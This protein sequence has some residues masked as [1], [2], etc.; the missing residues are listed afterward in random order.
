MRIDGA[1]QMKESLIAVL[2]AALLIPT[3]LLAHG[4]HK[5]KT[6]MGT[7]KSINASHIDLKTTAGKAMAV[8]LAKST[9]FMRGEKSV[10]RDQVKPRTRV[11]IVLGEDDK[12]AAQVKILASMK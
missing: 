3:L 5:H 1:E 4:G 9:R 2:V 12:T 11:V 10:G 7:V 6:I 8:P